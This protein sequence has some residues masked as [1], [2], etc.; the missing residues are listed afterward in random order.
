MVIENRRSLILDLFYNFFLPKLPT[1]KF[2]FFLSF[3]FLGCN[4]E[5]YLQPN[6]SKS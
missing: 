1:I 6:K 3:V 5:H 4:G 2:W